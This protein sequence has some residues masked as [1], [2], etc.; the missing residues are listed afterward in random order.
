MRFTLPQRKGGLLSPAAVLAVG[1]C[2]FAGSVSASLGDHLPEFRE[3]VEVSSAK[4]MGLWRANGGRKG[5]GGGS[6]W[7]RGEM[8]GESVWGRYPCHREREEKS[9]N[10]GRTGYRLEDHH[11][12]H[13]AKGISS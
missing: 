10:L 13:F 2:L 8:G 12:H 5:T 7:E 6:G 1:I 3:C 9:Q 11:G 4:G